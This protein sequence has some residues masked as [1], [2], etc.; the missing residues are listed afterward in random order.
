MRRIVIMAMSEVGI[1]CA[2]Q[3]KKACP[4]DEVNILVSE[5]GLNTFPTSPHAAIQ[6]A[7]LKQI[8]R[9]SCRERV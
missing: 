9:A 1:T 2:K 3:I 6:S 7:V 5:A 8:G 4:Q